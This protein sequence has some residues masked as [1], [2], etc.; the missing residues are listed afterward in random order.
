MKTITLA[1]PW[2]FHSIET[3]IDYEAGSHEVRDDI[4]EAAKA[5]GVTEGTSDGDGTA[6][7]R[8]AGRSRKA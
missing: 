2:S 5:A 3:T 7:D 1:K 4:A 8:P 6:A